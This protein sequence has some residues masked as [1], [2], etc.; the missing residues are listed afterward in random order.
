MA[1]RDTSFGDFQPM[2]CKSC[3]TNFVDEAASTEKVQE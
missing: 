2:S 1:G 3:L